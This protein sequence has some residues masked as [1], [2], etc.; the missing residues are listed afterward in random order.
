ME[1]PFT[2]C[3]PAVMYLFLSNRFLHQLETGV[4]L[5][6]RLV[7][8]RC[9]WLEAVQGEEQRVEPLD[10]HCVVKPRTQEVHCLLQ[11]VFQVRPPTVAHHAVVDGFA[12]VELPP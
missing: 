11:Q 8:M 12:A 6:E 7:L 5:G 4:I 9:C 10:Q 2:T 1:H 3:L